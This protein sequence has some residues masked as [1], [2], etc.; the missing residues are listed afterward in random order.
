MLCGCPVLVV[1]RDRE[2]RVGGCRQVLDDERDVLRGLDRRPRAA[3]WRRRGARTRAPPPPAA[4]LGTG[5]A[6]GRRRA[7]VRQQPRAEEQAA[8]PGATRARRRSPSASAGAAR[9]EMPGPVGV[10]RR[11]VLPRASSSQP[12]SV[13]TSASR[14]GSAPSRRRSSPSTSRVIAIATSSG[15]NEGGGMWTPG[16][17]ARRRREHAQRQRLAVPRRDPRRSRGRRLAAPVQQ[18]DAEDRPR[19]RQPDPARDEPEPSMNTPD[20]ARGSARTTARACGC[21]PAAARRQPALAAARRARPSRTC[22][23]SR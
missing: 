12:A 11:E 17:R 16:R 10:D 21:P 4:P 23:S 6:L 20:R 18:R 22:R 14:R 3:G 5:A 19:R 9:V 2:R 8:E 13:S 1:E 15:R 7:G